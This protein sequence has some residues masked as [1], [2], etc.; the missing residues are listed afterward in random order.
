MCV[1][2]GDVYTAHMWRPEDTQKVA[3]PSTMWILGVQLRC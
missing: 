3:L 1:H 2:A